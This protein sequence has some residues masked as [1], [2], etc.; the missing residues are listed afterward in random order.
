MAGDHRRRHPRVV[1]IE[2]L[3]VGADARVAAVAVVVAGAGVVE[4]AEAVEVVAAEGGA[5][6]TRT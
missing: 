6:A 5:E 1:A 3:R 2:A 4:E